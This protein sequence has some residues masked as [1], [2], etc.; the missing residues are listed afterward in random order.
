M[1]KKRLL[2][3][4]LAIPLLLA[5][6]SNNKK[7]ED[8]KVDPIPELPETPDGY[9]DRLPD[10]AVDGEILHAFGWSFN[11][12]KKNLPAIAEAGFK[13][14]QTSP[15]QEP[16]S[17][18]AFWWAYYQPLSFTIAEKTPLGTKEEFASM[19]AAAEELGVKII[20]DVVANHLANISDSELESDGTPKVSADVEK[21]E[22]Y[23]YEHRNDSTDPT[24][25]HNKNAQGSGA[26]TQYYQYGALPDLNTGN[27][28]VQE[29]VL[30]FLKEC[31]DAGADGF[32]FDAA[33]HIETPTD[34]QY[35]SDFWPNTVG[36]AKEYYAT[37]NNDDLYVYGE[38]LGDPGGGRT[39]NDYATYMNMTDDHYIASYSSAFASSD[40]DRLV[41]ATY[42]KSLDAS[43]LI[44][45]IESH[46]TYVNASSHSSSVRVKKMWAI[47]ASRKGSQG[48]FFARPDANIT[49][50]KVEDYTFESETIAAV[51]R[52]HNRF[53]NAEE[54]RFAEGAFY[55]MERYDSTQAGAVIVDMANNSG[56]FTTKQLT[57]LP[58]GVYY[59][60]L[61]GNKA[62]VYQG[63]LENFELGSS[64]IAVLTKSKNALRPEISVSD[65]DKMFVGSL[66]LTITT[67][68][69][70]TASYSINGAT[71]VSFTDSTTVTLGNVVDENNEITIEIYAANDQFN[72]TRSYTYKKAEIIEGYFNVFNINPTYFT[73]YSIYLWT[74]NDNT[75]TSLWSA[76]YTMQ[77]GVMLVDV[78]DLTG[79]L[80]AKFPKDY[81]ITTPTKWDSNVISQS[82]DITGSILEQGFYDAST[83]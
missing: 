51:N 55:V 82:A 61:T 71:A 37:K 46:D 74:W 15:I 20:V 4:L 21:Y 11:Q 80:L 2:F 73:D 41:S 28:Y 33:K 32:R 38:I 34:P 26:I 52:F 12:I 42:G 39:V 25:H 17:G 79:F 48:L 47:Q 56:A 40:A 76:D 27:T 75:N 69:A 54:N 67:K 49:V 16:K 64:R 36:V 77:D 57:H 53:L 7:Q 10:K 59:D 60:Q 8:P 58:D 43:K 35:A 66:D 3:S 68:N 29:R 19:C 78:D 22:P 50:G 13:S 1:N 14:V 81:V 6:C 45:W 24:F 65:R 83:F 44:T 18:G 5:S 72:I 70:T 9:V 63:R 30:A 62:T 23:L 31:I